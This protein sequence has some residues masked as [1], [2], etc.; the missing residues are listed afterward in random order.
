MVFRNNLY[1]KKSS[2]LLLY[3]LFIITVFNI[4][5]HSR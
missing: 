1:S 5:K 4:L 3:L 2:Y